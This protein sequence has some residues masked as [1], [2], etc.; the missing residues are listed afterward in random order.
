LISAWRRLVAVGR[1]SL[2]KAAL[3]AIPSRLRRSDRRP[4]QQVRAAPHH[5]RQSTI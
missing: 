4:R 5:H 1:F 2:S 3:D